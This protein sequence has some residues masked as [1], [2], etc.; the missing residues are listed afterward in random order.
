VGG[1]ARAL[2]AVEAADHLAAAARLL[3]QAPRRDATVLA[4]PRTA[5]V[6]SAL[7]EA[8]PE[9]GGLPSI[10]LSGAIYGLRSWPLWMDDQRPDKG[11]PRQPRDLDE[12]AS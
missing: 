9:D 3:R 7:R 10:D 4:A 5:D 11:H 8:A 2:A 1:T 6:L 12:P